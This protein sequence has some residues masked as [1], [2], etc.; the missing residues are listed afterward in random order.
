MA[1]LASGKFLNALEERMSYILVKQCSETKL[2]LNQDKTSAVIFTRRYSHT[3]E[4]ITLLEPLMFM[5]VEIE[6]AASMK[7]RRVHLHTKLHRKQYI[8]S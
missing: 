1:I 5:R 4:T 2:S 6:Y 3:F 7:Y 8:D